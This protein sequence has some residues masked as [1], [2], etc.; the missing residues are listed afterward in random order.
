[1]RRICLEA[2]THQDVPFEKLVEELQPERNLSSNPLFQVVFVLQNAPMPPLELPGLTI[3]PLAVDSG[4][5][6][7]DLILSITEVDDEL[8]GRLSYD[9]DLFV[10]A[11]IKR[12]AQ[13]FQVLLESIV[14]HPQERLSQ[15]SLLSADETN[16]YAP[17]DFPDMAL[18]QKDFE[19]LVLEISNASGE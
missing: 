17:T 19:N 16:G 1:V 12:L 18:S 2:Y 10:P 3:S 7:F 5:V 15:L 9:V 14:A 4:M 6:Q 13:H 11:T 8:R